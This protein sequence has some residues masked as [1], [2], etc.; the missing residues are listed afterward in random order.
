MFAK[1]SRYAQL[2]VS[3]P[4]NANGERLLGTNLRFISI[5]SGTFQHTVLGRDR[6]DLLALKYYGDPT[7]WWQISDANPNFPVPI[8]L[9][10]RS[11]IQEEVFSLVNPQIEIRFNNLVDA[12]VTAGEQVLFPLLDFSRSSLVVMAITPALRTQTIAAMSPNGFNFLTSFAWSDGVTTGEIFYFE[13]IAA[14]QG[15]RAFIGDILAAPGILEASSAVE[16]GTLHVIYNE[17]VIAR[18]RIMSLASLRGFELVPQLSQQIVQAGS[19]VVIPPN[20][21]S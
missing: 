12:L 8:A 19:Q 18:E 16:D 1:N 13:D 2:P 3:S 21:M 7:R 15:W 4:V 14:K 5:T 11:P 20:S 10:D 17:T 6:L 9:L